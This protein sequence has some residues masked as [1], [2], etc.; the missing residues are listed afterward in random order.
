M[1]QTQVMSEA[2]KVRLTPKQHKQIE[3]LA[4]QHNMSKPQYI[5][6]VVFG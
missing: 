3:K 2:V 5:R 6:E 1:K 4:K